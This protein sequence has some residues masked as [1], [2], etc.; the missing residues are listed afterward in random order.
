MAGQNQVLRRAQEARWGE[1]GGREE[2]GESHAG[3]EGKLRYL[4][5]PNGRPSAPYTPE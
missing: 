4:D 1:D 2:G 3:Q 5:L